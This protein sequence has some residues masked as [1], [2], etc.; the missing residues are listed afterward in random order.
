MR[1]CRANEWRLHTICPISTCRGASKRYRLPPPVQIRWAPE[2]RRIREEHGA[3]LRGELAAAYRA[4]DAER[5]EDPRLGPSEGAFLEMELKRGSR[6][7][8]VERKV[9]RFVP[10]AARLDADDRRIVGL[11]VPDEAREVFEAI[12]REYQEGELS[13]KGRPPRKNLVEAIESIRQARL[14]TF[15]TDDP[16][17]LP[18]PGQEM[19]WEVWCVRGLEREFEQLADRL[20]ARIGGPRT[21]FCTFPSMSCFRCWP[22]R[23]R[24]S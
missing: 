18:P 19:W 15:W 16:S 14:E 7:E 13:E 10:G 2:R 22:T 12:L 21:A 17:R 20:E 3:R 24:S 6:V 8:I 9:D 11:Y 1:K 23:R 4:F 5:R